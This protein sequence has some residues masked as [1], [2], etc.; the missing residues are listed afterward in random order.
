MTQISGKCLCGDISFSGDP[1]IKMMANCHC[2]DCRAATGAAF[3]SLIFVDH[4]E[5][6]IKGAPKVFNHIAESGADMEKLFCPNCG[7]QLFGRNSNRPGMLSVRA[8]AI[9]QTYIFKP[10]ANVFM[11]SRLPSTSIDP[12]L[13]AFPKMPG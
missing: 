8:G 10:A 11:N 12:A 6:E 2:G 4:S 1:E 7:S 3:G 5:I 9:D 13:K